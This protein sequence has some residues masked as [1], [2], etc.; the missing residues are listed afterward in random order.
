[1]IYSMIANFG[2]TKEQAE[3]MTEYDYTFLVI[4]KNLQQGSLD[5]N[6]I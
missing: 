3:N 1:M 6:N 4:I 5:E 2:M